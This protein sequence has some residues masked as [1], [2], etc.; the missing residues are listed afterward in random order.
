MTRDLCAILLTVFLLS[1][2]MS[3]VA[4]LIPLLIKDLDA[5]HAVIGQIQ[6]CYFFSFTVFTLVLSRWIDSA[7]SKRLIMAGLSIYSLSIASMP[8]M[9]AF[10]AFYGIRLFQGIGSALLF[11]PTEAAVNIISPPERRAANMGLYA[12]VFAG[13]F[14]I[15]PIFGTT[16]FEIHPKIPFLIAAG[17]CL[18][19]VLVLGYTYRDVRVNI[20]KSPPQLGPMLRRLVVPLTAA[21]SYALVEVSIAS[22]LSLYLDHLGITGATLGVIFTV[23]AIGGIASPVPAGKLADRI[24]K[25]R[26]LKLCGFVLLATLVT[27]N[28]TRSYVLICL[29]TFCVGLVAGALYPVAVSLICELVPPDR[30]G[31][32]NALFSFF[33]GIG[34]ILGPFLTGWIIE[35]TSITYLF[36]PMA[37][38]ALVFFVVAAVAPPGRLSDNA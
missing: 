24:G 2:G 23:F 26:I 14:T 16:L 29:L 11:A 27:Y 35:F 18:A 13:G 30:I 31:A 20:H 10:H 34:S 25:L 1:F 32:G 15:G 8:F 36:Y 9:T 17:L 38:S 37:A 22:F 19:A 3:F 7:G 28:M 33:Y 6:T 21:A 5:S 4:P 12:L